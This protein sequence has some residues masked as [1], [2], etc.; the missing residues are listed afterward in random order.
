MYRSLFRRWLEAIMAAFRPTDMPLTETSGLRT[1]LLTR[2]RAVVPATLHISDSDLL[3]AFDSFLHSHTG[4]GLSRRR[5]EAVQSIQNALT[6][7]ARRFSSQRIMMIHRE[8]AEN[9]ANH[10]TQPRQH[11]GLH[12]TY[13]GHLSADDLDYDDLGPAI[14]LTATV[15]MDAINWAQTIPELSGGLDH[16]IVLRPNAKIVLMC[17]DPAPDTWTPAREQLA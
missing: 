3:A 13:N 5:V 2:L 15:H 11:L 12:W 17:I 16:E 7:I 6:P 8:V 14:T 4:N 1:P 9:E 10:L